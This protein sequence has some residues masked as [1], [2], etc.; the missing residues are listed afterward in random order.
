MVVILLTNLMPRYLCVGCEINLPIFGYHFIYDILQS[1]FGYFWIFKNKEKI[2]I[3][4]KII[5]LKKKPPS[6]APKIMQ[7]S[8]EAR[9][10]KCGMKQNREKKLHTKLKHKFMIQ[11]EKQFLMS[12]SL[13]LC[14]WL[15]GIMVVSN[16][17]K[18]KEKKKKRRR[19]RRKKKKKR[20]DG[21]ESLQENFYKLVLVSQLQHN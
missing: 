21:H 9:H 7:H 14:L 6:P 20:P 12:F 1:S 8:V 13:S 15:N 11:N 2:I 3:Y 19:R 10:S 16:K 5:I 4:L 18:E 17:K